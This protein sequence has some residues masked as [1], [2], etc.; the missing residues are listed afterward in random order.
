MLFLNLLFYMLNNGI[1]LFFAGKKFSW[2][3]GMTRK[4]KMG[5]DI[6]F[7]L[8]LTGIAFMGLSDITFFQ[9][10]LMV[11]IGLITYLNLCKDGSILEKIYWV[12]LVQCITKC[13]TLFIKLIVMKFLPPYLP[14]YLSYGFDLLIIILLLSMQ[15]ISLFG[16]IK[17]SPKL[18][19]FGIPVLCVLTG[20]NVFWSIII[21]ILS[22]IH[23]LDFVILATS[24]LLI[25]YIIYFI[26]MDLLSKNIN[27]LTHI[28]NEY[29]NMKLKAKY[30]EEVEV[31]NEEVRRYK[32][33]LS[34]HLHM[35]YYFLEE[36]NVDSAKEYLDRL[37]IGLKNINKGFYYIKTN[38]EAMDFIVN[39]K[40]LIAREKGVK[41]QTKIGDMKEISIPNIDL[42]TLL[43]NLLDNA[44][45]ACELYKGNESF[46]DID[47]RLIKNNLSCSIKNSANPVKTDKKGNYLTNKKSGNHGFGMLQINQIIKQYNG[48][49]T[50]KYEDHVFETDILLMKT[51]E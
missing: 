14:H 37:G 27:R 40:L 41:V 50:R 23:N 51:K 11:F 1:L 17:V 9:M 7:K 38:N 49:I 48:F 2:K 19:Y 28:E 10:E 33:D 43:S 4:K 29:A 32:H 8:M 22:Y 47:I 34:N 20:T 6:L 18:T 46:I 39:S 3:G 30:Y 26:I 25:S 21:E 36:R 15:Y 24:L 12:T 31:I 44:I 42:C 5:V 35:L 13:A 45:E 16:I